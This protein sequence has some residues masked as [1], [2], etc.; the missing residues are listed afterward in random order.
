MLIRTTILAFSLIMLAGCSSQV[1]V[2]PVSGNAYSADT[3]AF[4]ESVRTFKISPTEAS[5][6]IHEKIKEPDAPNVD[7]RRPYVV[8]G[9]YYLFNNPQ[10][11]FYPLA[12]YYLNADTGK[13][14]YQSDPRVLRFGPFDS[15]YVHSNK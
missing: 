5:R 15:L 8:I 14:I 7:Y 4:D 9:R 13:I 1:T 6:L 12:G 11:F 3:A 2:G 10:F